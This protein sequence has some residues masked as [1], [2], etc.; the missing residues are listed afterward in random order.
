ML[1]P[2]PE[3]WAAFW[4]EHAD[5]LLR[6]AVAVIGRN[7]R[8]GVDAE[9][10]VSK[11]MTK[12]IARGI[13]NDRPALGT[14]MVSIRNASLDAIAAAKRLTDAD[15]DLDERISVEDIESDVDLSLLGAEASA[16]LAELP[17]REAHAIREKVM[18]DRHWSEVAPEVGVTTSQGLG[19]IVNSGLARLRKMPRFA[20][21][22]P[23]VSSAQAP[24]TTTGSTRATTP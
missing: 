5:A 16:A 19:K 1:A 20:E 8:A 15:I 13:R 21:L 12:L 4:D 3:G 10:I 11:V 22:L 18:N 17:E 14:V 24:S 2:P 6:A 23:D 9:D 7:S